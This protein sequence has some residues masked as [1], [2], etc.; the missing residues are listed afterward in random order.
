MKKTINE[1]QNNKKIK[2]KADNRVILLLHIGWL[3]FSD[4]F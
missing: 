3:S 4:Q 1:P 2:K